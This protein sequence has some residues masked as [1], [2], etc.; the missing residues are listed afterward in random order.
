MSGSEAGEVRWIACRL[1]DLTAIGYSVLA[2][3][4]PLGAQI[5]I[6]YDPLSHTRRCLRGCL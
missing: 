2:A 1:P 6:T 5:T 3:R 4:A